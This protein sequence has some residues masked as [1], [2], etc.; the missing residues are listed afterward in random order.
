[1]MANNVFA[2]RVASSLVAGAWTVAAMAASAEVGEEG[3][4]ELAAV[5]ERC[6]ALTNAFLPLDSFH[7]LQS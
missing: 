7:Q 4:A 3:A 6:T 5:T 2:M 1:M